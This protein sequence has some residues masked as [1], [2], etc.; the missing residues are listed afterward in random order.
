MF[1]TDPSS[2]RMTACAATSRAVVWWWRSLRRFARRRRRFAS[3]RLA[4]AARFDRL[5]RRCWDSS[6]CAALM[7]SCSCAS[8]RS[9]GIA[10]N[11]PG[12]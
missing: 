7:A 12:P 4:R 9:L 6:R 11:P 2:G 1:T 3:N 10:A 5:P 8:S